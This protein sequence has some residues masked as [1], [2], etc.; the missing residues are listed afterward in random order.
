MSGRY[1]RK[2]ISNT[3]LKQINEQVQALMYPNPS[4]SKD[5]NND[6]VVGLDFRHSFSHN[7]DYHKR[8]P[9][10][11]PMQRLGSNKFSESFEYR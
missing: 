8:S 2:S 10:T 7:F 11:K 1:N 4:V 5:Q 9:N 6:V 3:K